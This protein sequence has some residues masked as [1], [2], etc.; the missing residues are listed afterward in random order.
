M[1]SL[2]VAEDP[3]TDKGKHSKIGR[4]KLVKDND[5]NYQ[6]LSSIEYSE[7]YEK[8]EDQLVIVFENGKLLQEY[9]LET[10]RATCDIDLDRLDF[11][12]IMQTETFS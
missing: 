12:H 4:L 11:M 1:G 7:G 5:G 10:I 6:T 2:S 3:I 9:L 8:A